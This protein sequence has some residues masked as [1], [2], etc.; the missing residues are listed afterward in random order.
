MRVVPHRYRPTIAG[1]SALE[2]INSSKIRIL[3]RQTHRLQTLASAANAEHGSFRCPQPYGEVARPER[4][5]LPT[6]RFVVWCSIQL[7]YGR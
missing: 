6:P 4:F 1:Q 3:G 7:S 2:E 5:E